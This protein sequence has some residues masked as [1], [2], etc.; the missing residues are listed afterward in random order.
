MSLCNTDTSF[1]LFLTMHAGS[2]QQQ[3]NSPQLQGH[4]FLD[5]GVRISNSQQIPPPGNTARRTITE[6]TSLQQLQSLIQLIRQLNVPMGGGGDLTDQ[7]AVSSFPN[8]HAI[9]VTNVGHPST[10][11]ANTLSELPMQEK[12]NQSSALQQGECRSNQLHDSNGKSPTCK[13]SCEYI[14]IYIYVFL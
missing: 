11:Q 6:Q 12:S 3:D 14:Y 9:S 2:K 4:S 10:S 7:N 13:I 5:S 1:L 8:H